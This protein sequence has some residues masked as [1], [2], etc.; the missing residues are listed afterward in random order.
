[1]S[2]KQQD[3][4]KI[5]TSLNLAVLLVLITNQWL[6]HL[7][8]ENTTMFVEQPNVNNE[9]PS[10][11]QEIARLKGAIQ[12]ADLSQ[13]KLTKEIAKLKSEAKELKSEAKANDES[14]AKLAQAEAKLRSKLKAEAQDAEEEI[15][16]LK[17]V[18]R[19]A[20]GKSLLES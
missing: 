14:Q 2:T 13:S 16:R 12:A 3:I 10:D 19:D 9:K 7:V 8:K 6:A 15:S 1:M 18:G 11:S 20:R 4:I 5:I 17:A